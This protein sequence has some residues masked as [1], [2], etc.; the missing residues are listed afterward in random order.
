MST[1]EIEFHPM[2][3]E[4]AWYDTQE[5]ALAE[6]ARRESAPVHKHESITSSKTNR[7][8]WVVC[9]RFAD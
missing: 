3:I 5:Q 8:H 9:V 6:V 4:L 2:N 1:S 7:D